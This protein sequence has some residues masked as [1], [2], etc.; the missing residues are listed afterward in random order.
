MFRQKLVKKYCMFIICIFVA[1][2]FTTSVLSGVPGKITYFLT[3]YP[4]SKTI[5]LVWRSVGDNGNTGTAIT[6]DIRY[7]LSPI[8]DANWDSAT[9]VTGESNP[10]P[11][12]CAESF[13]VFGLSP[14]TQYYF[15]I[16]A[17]D[18]LSNWSPISKSPS[19]TTLALTD[20]IPPDKINN[21]IVSGTTAKSV[22]LTWTAPGDNNSS[23]IVASRYISYD[24][25]YSLSPITDANWDS[26]TKVAVTPTPQEMSRTETFTI[27]GLSPSTKYYFAIKT[28]DDVPN[29]SS[30]SNSPSA[31]TSALTDSTPP[32]QINNLAAINPTPTSV[33]LTWTAPGDDGNDYRVSKYDIRYYTFPILT[34][35]DWNLATPIDIY[36]LPIEW[37]GT[38]QSIMALGLSPNT[39]YYFAIKAADEVPNWSPISN[40]PGGTTSPLVTLPNNN[41]LF[42]EGAIYPNPTLAPIKIPYIIYWCAGPGEQPHETMNFSGLMWATKS[43]HDGMIAKGKLP[44]PYSYA[45]RVPTYTITNEWYLDTEEK[46]YNNYL[47]AAQEGYYGLSIDEWASNDSDTRVQ[48]S[49][50]ALR[51]VKQQYP[52]FFVTAAYFGDGFDEM[53][54]NGADVIDFY[55]PELYFYHGIK[56]YRTFTKRNTNWA[57]YRRL[58]GKTFPILGGG[59]IYDGYAPDDDLWIKYLRADS[60]Q[61]AGLGIGIFKLYNLTTEE[62]A[63]YDK[64]MDDD[65][66][67]LSPSVSINSP[68]NGAVVSASV[69]ISVTAT[70]NS[71]TTNPVVSYRYF[72]DN[73]LVKISASPTYTWNTAG[74]TQ[75][76]HIITVHAVSDDYLAGASQVTVTFNDTTPPT[77]INTL[78]SATATSNS[79]QLSWTAVGDD[80]NIG[81]ASN[82]DIR[83]ALTPITNSN[84]ATATQCSN[85]PIPQAVGTNQTYTVKGLN[86]STIYYFAIK[87]GDDVNNWSG[88]SNIVNKETDP[89]D[90][91]PPST[92]NDLTTSNPGGRTI[93]LNWSTVGDDGGTGTA[94]DYDIR[95][96]TYS[97]TSINWDWVSVAQCS[98]E[99]T[100]LIAGSNQSY[101]VNGL[102]ADTVYYFAM[103]VVDEVATNWT[104]ISNCA[105]GKTTEGTANLAI[106]TTA[107]ASSVEAGNGN[108]NPNYVIDGKL[109]TRW[110]SQSPYR[111]SEWIYVDLGITCT[112]TEVILRWEAAYGKDYQIQVSDNRMDWTTVATKIGGTGGTDD[113]ALN[114]SGRYVRMNGLARGPYGYSLYEF[115]V[116]GIPAL[117]ETTPPI[118]IIT[119]PGN[120]TTVTNSLLSLRGTA[121]D[122]LGL[123]K[124]EIKVGESGT[125]SAVN[126]LE[127]WSGTVR[128]KKGPNTVYVRATDISTHSNQKETTITVTYAPTTTVSNII[129]N[130]Q[131]YKSSSS[132]SGIT[133]NLSGGI[134]NSYITGEDGYY[135][136]MDLGIGD[137]SVEPKKEDWRFWPKKMEY[138]SLSIDMEG[139]NYICKPLSVTRIVSPQ[140]QISSGMAVTPIS[141]NSSV[142]SEISVL[143]P[144]GAFSTTANLTL[145]AIDVPVS[146]RRAIKVLGYGIEIV[147]D[148]NL[149]PK[150][151]LITISYDDISI[152]GYDESKLVVGWYDENN[153]RWEALQSTV[154]SSYNKVIAKSNHLSKFALLEL[155]P[156]TDLSNVKVYPSPFNPMKHAQ[157]MT[158]DNLTAGAVVKIYTLVGELARELVETGE[159][160][161]IVWDGKNEGG[162]TVASG[163]YVLYI[164]GTGETKKIK[165]G[166]EK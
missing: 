21:L 3:A 165:I 91:I 94:S 148:K 24:I 139:Q 159:R 6:Y 87:A 119:T 97:I 71:E 117:S 12:G 36:W 132:I 110:A 160:G 20:T 162:K 129:G 163:V 73:K 11:A 4:T 25:R 88:I 104:G 164:K 125:Y 109:G 17:S 136:F 100:P 22:T 150:E 111:D 127:T 89:T 107:Y 113:I 106:G 44:I 72:I 93:V 85:E 70:P 68:V 26:A 47:E 152:A 76:N 52:N 96:A 166:V 151:M 54:T 116:Y 14:S 56:D 149:Q 61:I 135:E 84:W 134:I 143:V 80:G 103:K 9:Q 34:E 147:N 64:V 138:T 95:Y 45:C 69:N 78:A 130:V 157:G 120:N 140:I 63:V 43:W 42:H 115:E 51:R 108:D 8:S 124:V 154:Y 114:G 30:S 75:G 55:V 131:V 82:Y 79:L 86:S 33:T 123:S 2:M 105:S 90:T 59:N 23:R 27:A 53:M 146:D 15:A 158:I 38:N 144:I 16:K 145:K 126:G 58:D 46:M 62:R 101:T 57:K 35:T 83:Y 128:L 161:S 102:N 98:G 99:P 122:N 142:D 31:T 48:K 18:K 121:S 92:V 67:K 65:F 112:I 40:S 13:I 137:Y 141:E 60:P 7:S 155:V 28:A 19:A 153:K 156:V 66:F 81:T 49:I 37:A 41:F 5:T 32:A 118:I 133:M 77:D 10:K 39:Q 50:N 1:C 29:W 74:Y